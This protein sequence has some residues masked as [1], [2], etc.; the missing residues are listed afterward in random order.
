MKVNIQRA[1]DTSSDQE[2]SLGI[3]Y[4]LRETVDFPLPSAM[5]PVITNP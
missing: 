5:V 1:N 3:L 4:R 2:A